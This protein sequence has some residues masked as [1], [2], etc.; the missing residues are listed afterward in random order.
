[1]LVVDDDEL[2]L[3]STSLVL[4][5]AGFKVLRAATG[6]DGLRLAREALPA[7]ILSD[8]Y[9]PDM[10]GIQFCERL[11]AEP[12][13]REIPVILL[14]SGVSAEEGL[15]LAQ[16]AGA[17]GFLTRP[18]GNRALVASVRAALGRASAAQRVTR[19]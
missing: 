1:V 7:L 17:Q 15:A 10:D 3:S 2:L 14:S 18:V 16:T 8:V 12:D 11:K 13:V 5:L 9:M 4:R 6:A 19:A